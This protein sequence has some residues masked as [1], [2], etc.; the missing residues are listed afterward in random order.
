MEE[1]EGT[2]PEEKQAM[3]A[4]IDRYPGMPQ[5]EKLLFRLGRRGEAMRSLDELNDPLMRQRLELAMEEMASQAGGEVEKIIT[6][7]RDQYI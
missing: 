7:L 1:V 4:V 6:A 2:F 3:L 5:E